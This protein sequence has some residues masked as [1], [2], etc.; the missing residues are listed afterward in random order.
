[1]IMV[2]GFL[3]R[4]TDETPAVY[5]CTMALPVLPPDEYQAKQLVSSSTLT[6]FLLG[7]EVFGKE[8]GATDKKVACSDASACAI[9]EPIAD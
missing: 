3:S 7:G 5:T 1:M 9:L 8:L 4:C 2:G 6:K